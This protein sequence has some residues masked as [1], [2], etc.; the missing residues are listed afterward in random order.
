MEMHNAWRK[1]AEEAEAQSSSS[2]ERLKNV[3]QAL[4]LFS[5]SS[6]LGL[7]EKN[8]ILSACDELRK[9]MVKEYG[10]DD[11]RDDWASAEFE[12]GDNVEGMP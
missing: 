5:A 11:T 9:I 12:N 1:R 10:L 3:E 6:A 7:S 8:S 4:R 2:I